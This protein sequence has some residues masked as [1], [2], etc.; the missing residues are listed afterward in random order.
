M[1]SLNVPVPSEV[2]RLAGNLARELPRARERARDEHTLV[3]KRLGE[4]EPFPAIQARVRG[5]LQGQPSFDVRV[6]GIE[7]FAEATTG[8]SPVVYLAVESPEL[9]RLHEQLTDR[10]PA[11]DGIEGEA[12]V[13][14]VTIARGGRHDA[15]QRLAERSIEPIAWTVTRLAFRDAKHGESA[16]S[17]SLPA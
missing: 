4:A 7:Y 14:H 9:H 6:T 10:F 12:Y 13:P 11:I 17:V 16:G 1:Y 3:L 15:A 5:T 2:A 8:S